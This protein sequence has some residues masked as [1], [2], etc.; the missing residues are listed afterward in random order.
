MV[1]R[2]LESITITHNPAVAERRGHIPG[3]KGGENGC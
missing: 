1:E 2:L 3:Y